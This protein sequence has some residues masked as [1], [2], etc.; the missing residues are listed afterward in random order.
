MYEMDKAAF[1]AFLAGLRKQKGMTQKELASRL[2]VSDKAVSKWERGLSIPDV[3][4]LEPLAEQLEVTVTELLR[5]RRME[6]EEPW[7]HRRWRA[8]F[9][10][11]SISPQACVP[12]TAAGSLSMYLA[13]CWPQWNWGYC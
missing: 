13:C 3:T 5:A 1:G 7:R 4:L 2:F 6:K 8:W 10:P 12:E 9:T 11:P